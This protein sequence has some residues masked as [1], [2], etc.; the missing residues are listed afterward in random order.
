MSYVAQLIN[1]V[2]VNRGVMF[3]IVLSYY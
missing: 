1:Y 2:L 3:D